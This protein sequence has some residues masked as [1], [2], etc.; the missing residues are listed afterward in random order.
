MRSCL[1]FAVALIAL[2]LLAPVM[3]VVALL[4]VLDSPGNPFYLAPRVGKSGRLFRMWKFRTMLPDASRLGPPI[5]GGEDPRITRLGRFLRR[6]KLDELPQFLNVL[7]GSMS[8][9]GPRPETPEIVALYTSAQRRLLSV[10]PG[11]TGKVQL[12]QLTDGEEAASIPPDVNA[13]EYYVEYLLNWKLRSDLEYLE[14]RTLL[15]D[16]GIIFATALLMLKSLVRR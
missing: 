11:I 10:K 6:F 12:L 7:T 16:T 13:A 9:V 3:V 4:V 8:L 5:T 2:A 1:D 15:T 14:H